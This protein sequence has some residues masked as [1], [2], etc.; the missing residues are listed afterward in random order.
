MNQKDDIRINYENEVK[1]LKVIVDGMR[2]D[3]LSDDVIVYYVCA[4]R[5]SIGIKYKY[6]RSKKY[7]NKIFQRNVEKY[8]NQFGPTT[9][10]LM[11]K[12]NNDAT[13]VIDA[14]LRV[15]ENYNK[16]KSDHGFED[17]DDVIMYRICVKDSNINFT[18]NDEYWTYS[19][20]HKWNNVRIKQNEVL[21]ILDQ[22]E[23]NNI[24]EIDYL[25]LSEILL[26]LF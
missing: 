1:N 7:R 10:N 9:T 24:T 17:T 22:Y 5:R 3:G 14:A 2:S 11:E 12:Y 6:L 23:K 8:G 20:Y 26:R 18:R 19:A 25:D 13:K 4:V 15:S 16:L 21:K